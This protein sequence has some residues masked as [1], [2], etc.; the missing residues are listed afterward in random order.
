[1]S[2]SP[3]KIPPKQL[4]KLEEKFKGGVH[5]IA[6]LQNKKAVTCFKQNPNNME[7]F[8]NCFQ[9]FYEKNVEL[10]S[11]IE[12]R[13]NW[14]LFQFGSCIESKLDL[15]NVLKFLGR[16]DENQ[17]LEQIMGNVDGAMNK[18]IQDL[19]WA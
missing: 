13:M 8:V 10:S 7:G 16:V 5:K 15:Q 1:M 3:M 6:Q 17:C 19:E 11:L 2:S 9:G 12:Q 14:C 18:S 4:K